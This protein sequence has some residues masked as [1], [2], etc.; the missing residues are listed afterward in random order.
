MA[1]IKPSDVAAAAFHLSGIAN[2]TAVVTSRTL[3][4]L[5]GRHLFLK[6]ENF[7]RAGAFKFRGAY[8]TISQLTDAQ[9][10]LGIMR[11][12]VAEMFEISEQEIIETLTFIWQ[13]LKILVEPSAAAALSPLLSGRYQTAGQRVGVILSGGNVDIADLLPIMLVENK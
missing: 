2:R 3:D 10:E 11:K 9:K 4:K 7:Q 8:N 1:E 5:T 6:C 13:R 12:Y